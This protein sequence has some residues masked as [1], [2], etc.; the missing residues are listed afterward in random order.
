MNAA[1][2]PPYPNETSPEFLRTLCQS[3]F[4]PEQLASFNKDALARVHQQ[5]AYA[6][7]HPPI[8]I[9]R[10]ATEG[11]Q[12]RDGG[13]IKKA[14]SPLRMKSEDGSWVRGALRGDYVVYNDGRTAQIVTGAGQHHDHVALVGSLLSNGD[15]IINTPQRITLIVAREG[16]PMA[17]DFLP[18]VE[19][20]AHHQN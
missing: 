9:Y 3:R 1:L 18:P 15:Q 19:S 11:S 12:T 7:A 10:I 14:T 2:L 20:E 4:S 13:V 16:V 8:A 17:E 6:Q 5:E